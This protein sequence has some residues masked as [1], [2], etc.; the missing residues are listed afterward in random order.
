MKTKNP[1]LDTMTLNISHIG[2]VFSVISISEWTHK[3]LIF[4]EKKSS[5][6]LKL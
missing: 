2:H 5:M 3:G 1:I 6:Y 4:P